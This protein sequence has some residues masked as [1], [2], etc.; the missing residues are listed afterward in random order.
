MTVKGKTVP[1]ELTVLMLEMREFQVLR[2]IVQKV[3][4][5][6]IDGL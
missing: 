2:G 5:K 6:F 1:L 4:T 3:K